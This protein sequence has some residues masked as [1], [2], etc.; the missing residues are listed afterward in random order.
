MYL[1]TCS[2]SVLVEA[3][4]L[5]WTEKPERRQPAAFSYADAAFVLVQTTIHITDSLFA[6]ALRNGEVVFNKRVFTKA[7]YKKMGG[8]VKVIDLGR[9]RMHPD[10]VITLR[11]DVPWVTFYDE[12]KPSP[13]LTSILRRWRLTW[14]AERPRPNNPMFIF[15]MGPGIIL[16]GSGLFFWL[17]Q[18]DVHASRA[19]G[20]CLL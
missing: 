10:H 9:T 11:P 4:T 18:P 2:A 6:K 15:S 5:L 20:R 3:L 17:E 8:E 1:P 14:R 13:L 12:K 7:T 19:Q 16:P